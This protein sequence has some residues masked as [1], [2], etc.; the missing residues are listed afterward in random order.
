MLS[1]ALPSEASVVFTWVARG[2]DFNGGRGAAD[3]FKLE[4]KGGRLIHQQFELFDDHVD[5]SGGLCRDFVDPGGK[6][7]DGIAALRVGNG[8][9]FRAVSML[10]MRDGRARNDGSGRIGNVPRDRR[11]SVQISPLRNMPGAG[12]KI[13]ICSFERKPLSIRQLR[14][15]GETGSI[16]YT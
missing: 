9:A 1:I 3:F 2:R 5:E 6:L 12:T 11:D 16:W 14:L 4:F 10:C 8:G 13:P 15:G 7:L